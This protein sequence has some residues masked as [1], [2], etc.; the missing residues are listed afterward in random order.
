MTAAA[1]E[2]D[3]DLWI[4]GDVASSGTVTRD[5][6]TRWRHRFEVRQAECAWHQRPQP[7]GI[8]RDEHL[9]RLREGAPPPLDAHGRRAPEIAPAAVG[10]RA[11][12]WRG[13]TRA[14]DP[15]LGRRGGRLTATAAVEPHGRATSPRQPMLEPAANALAMRPEEVGLDRG[16]AERRAGREARCR[17]ERA[18]EAR[19][20]AKAAA[21]RRRQQRRVAARAARRAAW[22]DLIFGPRG[23]G[24]GSGSDGGCGD[25]CGRGMGGGMGGGS[26][27]EEEKGGAGDE[28]LAA[29]AQ[30]VL[31]AAEAAVKRAAAAHAAAQR[32]LA[33]AGAPLAAVGAL[34]AAL[35]SR[36]TAL[37]AEAAEA[38]AE[39]ERLGE[40]MAALRAMGARFGSDDAF[41]EARADLRRREG[42]LG[43]RLELSRALVG[44]RR[45][46][47]AAVAR[48]RRAGNVARAEAEGVL[49]RAQEQADGAAAALGAAERAAAA[50]ADR[51]AAALPD[52]MRLRAPARC[53]SSDATHAVRARLQAFGSS[54]EA[55]WTA[56]T[57]P[58]GRRRGGGTGGDGGG[59]PVVRRGLA[60][61]E[62]RAGAA[63]QLRQLAVHFV[64]WCAFA[65]A[66][67]L[68]R[69][70]ALGARKTRLSLVCSA[71]GTPCCFV[72]ALSLRPT[73]TWAE[74][75]ARVARLPGWGGALAR[76]RDVLLLVTPEG[77]GAEREPPWG[78][79]SLQ[80]SRTQDHAVVRA[81]ALLPSAAA[82]LL[83]R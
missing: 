42:G 27:D 15:T 35:S 5:T 60:G 80:R 55:G 79:C 29:A 50:A 26:A 36:E 71:P 82:G 14:A 21:A 59:G 40:R 53:R 19:A 12:S 30:R 63:W 41:A 6:L 20:A 77:G 68:A 8:V 2:A 10:R 73:D 76:G 57:I 3:E 24:S 16:T 4:H 44:G 38:R 37:A 83:K 43:V 13:T 61:D 54:P 47:A 23:S 32:S 17:R 34:A 33:V 75:R 70:K 18:V 64:A 69:C 66:R 65:H 62:L 28:D 25:R 11:V 7:V 22:P 72:A 45:D 74:V 9:R 81:L 56:A 39:E 51:A 78:D 58:A 67:A 1:K 52:G 49:A 46:K 48:E 31:R